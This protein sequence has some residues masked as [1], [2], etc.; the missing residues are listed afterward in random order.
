MLFL[1]PPPLR[2]TYEKSYNAISQEEE[3]GEISFPDFVDLLLNG[4][5][6]YAEFLEE[7]GMEGTSAAIDTGLI[8]GLGVSNAWNPYWKQCGVCN[9]DMQPHYIL[10]LDH[11]QQDLQALIEVM[12]YPDKAKRFLDLD[13]QVKSGLR[14]VEE[15]YF[16]QLTKSEIRQLHEKYRA[17][18]ELFGFSPDYYIA[19]GQD[20]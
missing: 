19:M 11:Y 2:Y 10:H 16:S 12:G 18:H 7:N 1:V 8:D 9:P 15:H 13:H 4:P 6:E 3:G 20:E 14:E 17:D 5:L